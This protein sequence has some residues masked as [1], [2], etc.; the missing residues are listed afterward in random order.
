MMMMMV[1]KMNKRLVS[2]DY[3]GGACIGSGTRADSGRSSGI[4]ELN[5]SQ[6]YNS[7]KWI[8]VIIFTT[9][10]IIL[11]NIAIR[12]ALKKILTSF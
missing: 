10:L 6:D 4:S 5:Q 2:W 12:K 8:V 3:Q 11:Y 9:N 1:A 7:H